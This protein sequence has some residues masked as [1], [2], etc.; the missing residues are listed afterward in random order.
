MWQFRRP[1]DLVSQCVNAA[2]S[3]APDRI[4]FDP[5]SGAAVDDG[6]AVL[7]HADRGEAGAGFDETIAIAT[8]S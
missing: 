2:A 5:R 1:R 6:L 7:E 3:R 8:P 4:A